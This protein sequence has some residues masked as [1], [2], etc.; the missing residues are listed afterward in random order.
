MLRWLD[1]FPKVDGSSLC[2]LWNVGLCRGQDRSVESPRVDAAR[3]LRLGR[4]F[5][6]GGVRKAGAL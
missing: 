3:S 4:W 1:C 5:Q 6:H 2:R